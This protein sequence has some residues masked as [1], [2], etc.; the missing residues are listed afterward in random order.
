MAITFY[1]EFFFINKIAIKITKINCN[2]GY[3]IKFINILL[4]VGMAILIPPK[5]PPKNKNII[6]ALILS[7]IFLYF[8]NGTI[9]IKNHAIAPPV[10]NLSHQGVIGILS[11]FV[12]TFNSFRIELY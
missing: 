7:P 1:F 8:A 3:P 12:T 5:I 2:I 4:K 9:K 6:K 11:L 10:I